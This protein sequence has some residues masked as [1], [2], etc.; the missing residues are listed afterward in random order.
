[1]DTNEDLGNPLTDIVS[2][3][4]SAAGANHGNFNAKSWLFKNWYL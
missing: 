4:M 3:F 1:M 2:T